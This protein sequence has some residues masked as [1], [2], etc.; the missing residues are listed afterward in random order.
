MMFLKTQSTPA[1][2]ILST[3]RYQNPAAWA[4][5]RVMK[6]K[7]TTAESNNS[8]T[9]VRNSQS[10]QSS[11]LSPGL[12]D[13]VENKQIDKTE[14]NREIRFHRGAVIFGV[15]HLFKTQINPAREDIED[16]LWRVSVNILDYLQRLTPAVN[17]VV[18]FVELEGSLQLQ[19]DQTIDTLHRRG[20]QLAGDIGQYVWEIT[21]QRWDGW[22]LTVPQGPVF[23]RHHRVPAGYVAAML[24]W[25]AGRLL[26]K[27]EFHLTEEQG[28]FL[29]RRLPGEMQAVNYAVSREIQRLFAEDALYN[30][31]RDVIS[32]WNLVEDSLQD[33]LY[34]P[35]WEACPL[36]FGVKQ[37][38]GS[39]AEFLMQRGETDRVYWYG[40]TLIGIRGLKDLEEALLAES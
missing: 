3:S 11:T 29:L 36:T 39:A 22:T 37:N 14:N 15:M 34:R 19:I 12:I 18:R 40:R 9:I 1:C 32:A 21:S 31:P 4:A 38:Y 33:G 25:I 13:N 35:R 7:I 28:L 26:V 23:Y 8:V 20:A 16:V 27:G 17:W 10:W 2:S 30:P 24:P 6:R 5:K